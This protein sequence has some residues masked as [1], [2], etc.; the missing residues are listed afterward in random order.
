MLRIEWCLLC[1]KY[2]LL[3]TSLWC[4]YRDTVLELVKLK[5]LIYGYNGYYKYYILCG[6]V[7]RMLHESIG[8]RVTL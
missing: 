4:I 8:Y 1:F 7:L 2:W 5:Y 3:I 6:T